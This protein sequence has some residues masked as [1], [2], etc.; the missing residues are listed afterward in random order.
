MSLLK[1]YFKISLISTATAKGIFANDINL[2]YGYDFDV[3]CFK[4][5]GKTYY[6]KFNNLIINDKSYNLTENEKLANLVFNKLFVKFNGK[7]AKIKEEIID[8]SKKNEFNKE[9]YNELIFKTSI[10]KLNRQQLSNGSYLKVIK[11]DGKYYSDFYDLENDNEIYLEDAFGTEK[12]KEDTYERKDLYVVNSIRINNKD[13]EKVIETITSISQYKG[14]ELADKL[15]SFCRNHIDINSFNELNKDTNFKDEI[16]K[17]FKYSDDYINPYDVKNALAAGY[18][19]KVLND[20]VN[21]LK[22]ERDS[23]I[24][25]NKEFYL[26]VMLYNDK[27]LDFNYEYFKVRPNTTYAELYKIVLDKCVKN[28]NTT[29]DYVYTKLYINDNKID[30]IESVKKKIGLDIINFTLHYYKSEY[31]KTTDTE[32]AVV[33]LG[34]AGD[35]DKKAKEEKVKIEEDINKIEKEIEIKKNNIS[36]LKVGDSTVE[37][38]NNVVELTFNNDEIDSTVKEI[39]EDKEKKENE[40]KEKK[41]KKDDKKEKKEDEENN[42][43][44]INNIKENKKNEEKPSGICNCGKKQKQNKI[45]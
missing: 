35:D 11:H 28:L 6:F 26:K 37:D 33:S 44:N 4:D 29:S 19:N 22:N 2:V 13:L 18:L 41:N 43:N 34:K 39:K 25:E 21:D 7:F 14:E 20:K 3:F 38:S 32:E 27:K 8:A 15:L 9:D 45:R 40:E 5:N 10:T 12:W 42:I 30:D 23:I 24:K 16:I 36:E 1:R 17:K 31:P